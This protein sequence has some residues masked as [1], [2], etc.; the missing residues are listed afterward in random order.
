MLDTTSPAQIRAVDI[1]AQSTL[2]IVAS[3]S[4]TTLETADLFAYFH[5]LFS[6]ELA[7]PGDHFIAITDAGSWLSKQAVEHGFRR[8]FINPSDI[9]G[10]YSVLSYF[11][12]VPAA[13][14][15]VDLEVILERLRSFAESTRTPQGEAEVLD[16]AVLM[17]ENALRGKNKL[18]LDIAQPVQKLSLWIEQLVA[19]STGKNGTGIL[20]LVNPA[21]DPGHYAKDCIVAS[22]SFG[23]NPVRP[24]DNPGP[25]AIPRVNL[26]MHDALDLG[27]EFL[28]W[29]MATAL[30]A[31]IIKV[32]PFDQPD[33]ELAKV[34]TRHIIESGT[35]GIFETVLDMPQYS[36]S[37]P[38]LGAAEYQDKHDTA[39]LFDD[40]AR[41]A[42]KSD[43]F[44][45]L[46]YLPI[47]DDN[48]TRLEIL[49][50][51]L[52]TRLDK[53][54]TCGFG[55][56]YLHS[57]GQLHKGGPQ[58]GCFM[59]IVDTDAGELAIPGRHYG[60]HELHRAQA[61]GDFAVIEE[62]HLPIMRI[63]LKGDRLGAL[64]FLTS[65]LG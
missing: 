39:A 64:D 60:F 62:K 11:G 20:P 34:K 22:I 46:A 5:Q 59:Q 52:S 50:Q 51:T 17:G 7:N 38:L 30:A 56:R 31:A 12:L 25:A 35:F 19:E 55:P 44:G 43:Y 61:D 18:V 6:Q 42:A 10:R 26:H 33:V 28:R 13:L 8:T 36:I 15:G 41:V 40:F 53:P 32:N 58:S 21:P 9:G 1:N 3:K 16:L 48:A 45:I 14:M 29:E 23:E 63:E 54:T 37:C 27:S 65:E 57:T 2:V 49:R 4:G 24:A 47:N